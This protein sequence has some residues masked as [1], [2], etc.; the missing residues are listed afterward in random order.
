MANQLLYSIRR[1]IDAKR[2]V[3]AL[4]IALGLIAAPPF[5]VTAG[6]AEFGNMQA[7]EIRDGEAPTPEIPGLQLQG[8]GIG[9]I[10][11]AFG[12]GQA[13]ARNGSSDAALSGYRTVAFDQALIDEIGTQSSNSQACLGYAYAYAHSIMDGRIHSWTEYDSRGGRSE[14]NYYG[15]R[16]TETF[17]YLT[18]GT[19]QST[20]RTAYD[21]IGAGM[22]CIVWVRSSQSSTHWVALI[23]CRTGAEPDAL[24]LSDFL[25]LD[26]AHLTPTTPEQ[27]DCRGYYLRLGYEN[28]RIPK[29]ASVPVSGIVPPESGVTVVGS[30]G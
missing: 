22:P 13:T 23:G 8:A 4:A 2:L 14:R 10:L 27:L 1:R 12:P 19:K 25:M 21:A 6:E 3:A 26:P 20:L 7:L 11:G 5:T 24:Q 18:C 16:V 15:R 30:Q 29:M 9:Q 17:E 28:V